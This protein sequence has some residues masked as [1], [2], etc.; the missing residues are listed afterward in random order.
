[1]DNPCFDT[2][3]NH[4]N[5]LK[6]SKIKKSKTKKVENSLKN[7]LLNVIPQVLPKSEQSILKKFVFVSE[8]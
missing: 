4:L 6:K 7:I 5:D 3:T 8:K 1:M 2:S